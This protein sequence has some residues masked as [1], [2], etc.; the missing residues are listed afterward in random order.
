[1]LPH[2]ASLEH[3]LVLLRVS[4]YAQLLGFFGLSCYLFSVYYSLGY[5]Y[6]TVLVASFFCIV[7]LVYYS[8]IHY[9]LKRGSRL[10]RV[11]FMGLSTVSSLNLLHYGL[12]TGYFWHTR[13]HTMETAMMLYW[14]ILHLI[15]QI[16]ALLTYNPDAD[17]YFQKPARLKEK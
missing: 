12:V 1:M 4:M 7:V 5:G 2:S 6:Q 14:V 8:S 9:G 17:V 13:T 16:S 3:A 10:A 15:Q 11:V